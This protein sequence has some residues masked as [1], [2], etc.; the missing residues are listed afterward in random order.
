MTNEL[1]SELQNSIEEAVAKAFKA[2]HKL[3]RFKLDVSTDGELLNT[4]SAL[5]FLGEIGYHIKEKTL[6]N[7]LNQRR[8]PFSK[9]GKSL[10]FK[11]SELAEWAKARS[12]NVLCKTSANDVQCLTSQN[13]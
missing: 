8:I 6:R 12:V 11:K 7:L 4:K 2:H 3:N 5:V 10:V 9:Y 1:K 13:A